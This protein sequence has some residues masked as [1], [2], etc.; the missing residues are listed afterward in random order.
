VAKEV[1]VEM[2]FKFTKF[3]TNTRIDKLYQPHKGLSSS[4]QFTTPKSHQCN[5]NQISRHFVSGY[6]RT[7][8]FCD[9]SSCYSAAKA[10]TR[11]YCNFYLLKNH[12]SYINLTT[13][14][15]SE[16]YSPIWIP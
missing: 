8:F 2:F 12:I 5:H 7:E 4:K 3:D 6:E 15:T 11:Y 10:S 1:Q 14:K 9:P 13:A 16:K